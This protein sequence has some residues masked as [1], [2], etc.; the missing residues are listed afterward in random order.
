MECPFPHK[1]T[2]SRASRALS[3]LFSVLL[4]APC[5][6]SFGANAI[7]VENQGFEVDYDKDLFPDGWEVQDE[8]TLALR[9]QSL[10]GS[11]CAALQP[12]SGKERARIRS[13]SFPLKPGKMY[14]V[15]AWKRSLKEIP[16]GL[17][18]ELVDEAGEPLAA[19]TSRSIS[20]LFWSPSNL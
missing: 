4:W 15:S 19:W 18:L 16:V 3:F 2:G 5:G 13:S 11:W 9:E 20:T 1:R 7:P 6:R 14:V 10:E 17:S 12:L 8:A